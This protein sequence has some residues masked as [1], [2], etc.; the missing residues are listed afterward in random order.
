MNIQKVLAT[1]NSLDNIDP[2]TLCDGQHLIQ[3]DFIEAQL[4]CTLCEYKDNLTQMKGFRLIMRGIKGIREYKGYKDLYGFM[5]KIDDHH[6]SVTS[7]A[8]VIK[9]FVPPKVVCHMLDTIQH[10][11]VTKYRRITHN[12]SKTS[13]TCNVV[14]DMI[15]DS[16]IIHV[17]FAYND[18]GIPEDVVYSY[19]K[20]VCL[21]S[22]NCG[23]IFRMIFV[24]ET[25]V[26]KTITGL[27][28]DIRDDMYVLCTL[29]KIEITPTED[30]YQH[31]INCTPH[32]LQF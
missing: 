18:Y 7:A 13:D 21:L 2:S 12:H 11:T 23:M 9:P 27:G 30:T 16:S 20:L 17:H 25:K 14:L 29:K 24:T 32:L 6:D 31:I 5:E 15:P 1:V 4:L 3:T 10:K 28:Q 8:N 19:E 22:T 26:V